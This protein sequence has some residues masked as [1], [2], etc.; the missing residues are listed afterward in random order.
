MIHEGFFM[1]L[2]FS[3]LCIAL[4]GRALESQQLFLPVA[5]KLANMTPED[6]GR[7]KEVSRQHVYL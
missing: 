2:M 7:G 5:L 6:E 4:L 1:S 3:V